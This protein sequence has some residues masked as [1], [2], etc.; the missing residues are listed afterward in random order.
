MRA[1]VLLLTVLLL[2]PGAMAKDLPAGGM[3][4]EEI[5]GWLQAKGLTADI[6]TS[7]SG[8]RSLSSAA[9]SGK[10]HIN[11]YDC[12]DNRCGSLQF[13]QGFDTKGKFGPDAMNAWNRENRWARAYA[14]KVNDPWIEYDVDLTP[15][16][17][18]ELLDDQFAIWRDVLG[19]FH[20]QIGW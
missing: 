11:T 20:K 7:A 4:L 12:K 14:D 2:A 1:P 5:A 8:V 10:F 9:D 13:S 15:G 19:R 3:T 16:G 18:Y 17:S 6:E